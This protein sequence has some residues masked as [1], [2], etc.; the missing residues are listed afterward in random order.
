[1]SSLDPIFRPK[2]VAVIGASTRKGAIGHQIVRNIIDFE[3][4]G[5]LFPVNPR[6][7]FTHSIKCYHSI[8]DIPD[9]VDL[10]VIVVPKESV[11]EVVEQCGEK[12]VKGL[13]VISAG[14]KEIGGQG[15]EREQKLM[16]IVRRHGMRMIGPNCMGV[17]NA[18]PDVRLNA[19]FAPTQP[20]QGRIGFMSQSGALGVAI[21]NVAQRAHIGFSY[22]ASVGNKADISGN[23]LL[24]YWENDDQ[25]EVIAL[26]LE[27][28]GDPRSF[29]P[30]ARRISKKKPI[31]VVKSG[32][33]EAGARAA[34]SHTGAMVA[35]DVAVDALLHQ[36][37]VIRAFDI[38][39]MLDL[40]LAFTKCP[41]PCGNRV[42][43]LTNAGG[44][45][46]IATDAC[47]SLGLKIATL[48]PETVEGLRRFL[49]PEASIVNPVDMI[50]SAVADDYRR[51]LELILADPDNDMVIVTFVP[52]MMI[53]PVDII[54]AVTEVKQRF[55]KPVL[56]VFMAEE[57][58]FEQVPLIVPDSPPVYRFPESAARACAELYHYHTWRSRPKG[59]VAVADVDR[60]RAAKILESRQR[61]GGGYLEQLEAY[62][63]LAAYGFRY[64]RLKLV[65]TIEDGLEAAEELGY[66]L[67]LKVAGRGIVHKSDIGGV[68]VDIRDGKEFVEAFRTMKKALTKH[69]VIDRVEGYY[70]QEMGKTGQ[71][72]ILGMV[73]DPTYGPLLM[74]GLGG[75]YVEVLRDV[76]FRVVP[77]TDV[78]AEEMV[79]SIRGYPLLT[80]MRGEEGVHIETL[81]ESL[82]RL[83]QLVTDFHCIGELDVNP[84]IAAPRPEDCKV[85][86]VRINVSPAPC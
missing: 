23:D 68:I 73:Y 39:E 42:A 84:F 79:T 16:E 2:S 57:T 12:G 21:L 26:Y 45:A 9:E 31:I 13:I 5:K 63:V 14:F 17:F 8:T 36:C 85:V 25:T 56:G 62:E 67:V 41:V 43:I 52:P 66:P 30:L 44:P 47:V 74:F 49:P 38:E 64:C 86:D 34:S 70:V 55:E 54:R 77:I 32:R 82:Q 75:K 69:G 61:G 59:E 15:I 83:S 60:E 65:D 53:N 51:A 72:V 50:A 1:M 76:I 33:T 58:F 19:T 40:I 4:N 78:D 6:A 71:E 46:I 22:F 11:L 28:F 48:S 18:D 81:V 29:T 10:A 20:S 27:S 37:G 35:R 7:E 80:G 3:F 24:E